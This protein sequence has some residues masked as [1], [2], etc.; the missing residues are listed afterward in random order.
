M[1]RVRDSSGIGRRRLVGHR[2]P[3]SQLDASR[4]R[5]SRS[6]RVE[7]GWS[8]TSRLASAR[9][10]GA[11]GVHARRGYRAAP[12]G[13]RCARAIDVGA[14]TYCSSVT[15]TPWRAAWRELPRPWRCSPRR[16]SSSSLRAVTRSA[17]RSWLGHSD[18]TSRRELPVERVGPVLVTCSAARVLQRPCRHHQVRADHGAARSA[19]GV[20]LAVLADKWLRGSACSAPC[21]RRRLPRRSPSPA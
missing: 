19:L 17:R 14:F 6:T 10:G 5:Q 1:G 11:S 7:V 3:P 21:S 16:S 4:P 15:S 12:R 18:A 9:I 20:G 13:P 8:E 2:C